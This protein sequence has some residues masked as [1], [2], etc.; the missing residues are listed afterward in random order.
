MHAPEL[1]LR[2]GSQK[3]LCAKVYIGSTLSLFGLPAVY[4]KFWNMLVMN[5][6]CG[7]LPPRPG[8]NTA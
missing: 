3:L 6:F 2:V 4:L 8:G 7:A 1:H 5:G